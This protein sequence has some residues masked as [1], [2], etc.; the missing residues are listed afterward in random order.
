MAHDG[1]PSRGGSTA[2]RREFL[3]GAAAMGVA[4]PGLA[5]A[6]RKRAQPADKP[7]LAYVGTYSSRV[8]PEGGTGHGRGIYL[9]EMNPSTGE[10]SQRDLFVNELSPSWLALDPSKTHLYA[11]NEMDHFNRTKSGSVSAFRI[12]RSN[13]H[14]TP[15][16]TVSSEGAGPAYVSVHPSGKYV[17]VANYAGGTLAVLPIR[18]NGELGPPTD[19]KHDRGAIGPEHAASAAPGSFAIS[20]HD[21]GPHVHM[22][23]AD[24][25]GRFVISTDLAMDRIFTWKFDLQKGTLSPNSP[26]SV[27]LPPGDGPRHFRFHPNGRWMYSL[28]EEASTLVHFDYDPA[29]GTLN[30]RQTVSSLPPGFAGTSFGSEVRVSDDGRFV[31]AANR[32]HNSVTFFSIGKS[33]ALMYAG[34]AWARGDY[35]RHFNIDPTGNFLCSCNQRSDA[36]TTF[37]IHQE[38]GSLT[39]TGYYTAIGTPAIIEFLA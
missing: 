14:L 2:S 10:L 6:A 26:A 12:D 13:G 35:P 7:V 9:L 27:A 19:V 23:R 38:N 16:N 25:S 17:L 29:R 11:A 21:D 15:L 32:L 8:G 20:G 37:R 5:R 18:S 4:V 28:Q 39:F 1:A 31:Y 33:G 30:A 22:V 3:K 34:E 36:V 24:P